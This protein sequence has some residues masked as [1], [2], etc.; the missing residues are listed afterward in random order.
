MKMASPSHMLGLNQ[1]Q[2]IHG[3]LSV[4]IH[5]TDYE[6]YLHVWFLTVIIQVYTL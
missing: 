4:V 5:T 1:W 2:L 3:F 6:M